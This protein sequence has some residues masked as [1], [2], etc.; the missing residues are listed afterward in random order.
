[1][2]LISYIKNQYNIEAN[3]AVGNS[4]FATEPFIKI[5]LD[6]E[7]LRSLEKALSSQVENAPRPNW[8]VPG[9]R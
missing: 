5:E 2:V 1:M 9:A 4:L 8:A 6:T 7:K 3:I